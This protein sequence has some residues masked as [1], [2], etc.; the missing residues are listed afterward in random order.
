MLFSIS[1]DIIG[2]LHTFFMMSKGGSK[3]VSSQMIIFV[4]EYSEGEYTKS[5]NIARRNKAGE[6]LRSLFVI[7]K[8][9][10]NVICS[11][12]DLTNLGTL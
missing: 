6:D 12:D 10:E 3:P 2:L 1:I 4:G 5:G 9:G 7:I 11:F 8:K